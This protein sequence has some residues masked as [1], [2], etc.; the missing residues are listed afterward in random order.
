MEI[1]RHN[2]RVEA[3]AFGKLSEADARM[4]EEEAKLDDDLRELIHLYQ[5]ETRG[6]E[7]LFQYQLRKKMETWDSNRKA[8][9]LI[10]NMWNKYFKFYMLAAAIVALILC[11]WLL[12]PT[13]KNNSHLAFV[14][15]NAPK[16]DYTVRGMSIEGSLNEG[17]QYLEDSAF[18]KAIFFFEHCD[19]TDKVKDRCSI[20]LAHTYFLK[21]LQERSDTDLKM[22]QKIYDDLEKASFEKIIKEHAEWYGCLVA[23]ALGELPLQKLETISGDPDHS[24]YQQS[25]Q[26]M[27]EL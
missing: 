23:V 4:L 1:Y 24:F 27:E 22:A 6:I 14:I 25:Q 11:T 12:W 13:P 2:K 20:L 26:L 17:I 19:T 15:S 16:L 5:L 3:Y 10:P 21:G 18:Q 8:A 9:R 7:L